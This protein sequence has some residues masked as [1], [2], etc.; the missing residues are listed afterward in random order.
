M[1]F[2]EVIKARRSFRKFKSQSFPDSAVEVALSDAILAPNSSNTQTWDFHW[3]KSSASIKAK[4]VN[5]C[6]NQS[7]AKTANHLIV[8]TANSNLWKR[9]NQPLIKWAEDSN[10]HS[11][12]LIYY[13]KLIPIFYRSGFLN[14]FAPLKWLISL[15]V[16]SFRPMMRVPFTIGDNQEVAIKS[17]ALA[18]E[19]LALS[20][21]NQGGG[22]CMMEGFD[23]WPI[24]SALS[25]RWSDRVVMVIAIG[26]PDETGLWGPQFRLP[27]QEVIHIHS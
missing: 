12:V 22:T 11:S 24:R 13:K 23:E 7:A 27:K 26:Y 8:V 14:F 6:L 16:G 17:A 20:I 2:S 5:A 3:I 4:I 25:L 21:V 1:E 18:C 19:N 10:A 9:S 15:I